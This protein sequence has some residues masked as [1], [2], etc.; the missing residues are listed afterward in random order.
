M[1]DDDQPESPHTRFHRARRVVNHVDPVHLIAIGAPD[2][3]YDPEVRD[4]IRL[5]QPVSPADVA[6]VFGAWFGPGAV[7]DED[8][9]AIAAGLAR[10]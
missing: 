8:A 10:P 5:T 4:L 6:N 9:A 7:A 3:E 1:R 2:D